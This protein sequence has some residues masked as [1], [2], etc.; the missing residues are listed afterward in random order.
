VDTAPHLRRT[1]GLT[2]LVLLG[3]VAIVNVNVVPPV[4]G[5]GWATLGLWL[6]AWLAFF[7][8]EAIAVL[9]LSKRYPGEGGVYLWCRE[10]FGDLHGFI[11]G[12]CYWTNSLFYV[13]VLLVYVAGVAAFAG[14]D[15][16]AGLVDDRGF[17][18]TVAFGWLAFITWANIRGLRV[19]KW[20]NN[21]GGAGGVLTVILVALAAAVARWNGTAASPPLVSGTP[22]DM[23][24]AL[25]VMCFAFIGIEL[26]STM[27]DEIRHPARDVPRSVVITGIIAL[28]AYLLV[29]D[30][31]LVLVPPGELGAIQGV[32]QAVHQGADSAGAAW[33]VAPIAVVMAIAV[34][35]S[36][37]AWFAGPARIPFV[38]GLDHALPAA[39]GRVHP[40]YGSPHVALLTCAVISAA[41]TAM[42]LAGST[43]AEAYQVLLRAA[44]VINL[45]PFVYA[46]L[47][48]LTLEGATAVQ[49]IAGAVGSVVTAAGIVAVFLPTGDVGDVWVFELKMAAG[50]GIPVAVG[51]WLFWRSHGRPIA[52]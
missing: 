21:I 1:L 15:R 23:A 32:M 28:L 41:L 3:T 45:V 43:V 8:P 38:A 25:G 52:R 12:W 26:A 11:A 19:G 39:L 9:A 44:V 40:R 51:L 16:W 50:V 37:S 46:F 34:G 49:R 4:G 27:A 36:A 29:A 35:G 22:T 7:V 31:L 30:A 5:F 24:G 6:L 17:I 10:H 14:G 48:L 42:S 2:D 18:A 47:A 33:L 13:P 20:I